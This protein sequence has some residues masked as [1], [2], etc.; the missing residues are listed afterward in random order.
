MRSPWLTE[1]DLAELDVVADALTACIWEH[2]ERCAGC[3]DLGHACPPLRE[4]IEAAIRWAEYRALRSKADALR[5]RR[6]TAALAALE[7]R[8]AA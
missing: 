5:Q 8:A 4:A 7:R 3:R 2:K 1:A 6:L